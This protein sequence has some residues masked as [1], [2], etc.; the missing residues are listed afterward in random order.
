VAWSCDLLSG[1]HGL[2]EALAWPAAAGGV[3]PPQILAADLPGQPLAE[4]RTHIAHRRAAERAGL[5]G[6]QPAK[7]QALDVPGAPAVH[8][9]QQGRLGADPHL[10]PGLLW[11]GAQ[12]DGQVGQEHQVPWGAVGMAGEQV[13]QHLAVRLRDLAVEQGGGG[14][15]QHPAGLRRQ[16]GQGLVQQDAQVTVI[17]PAGV[18]LLA[19]G[20]GAKPTHQRSLIRASPSPNRLPGRSPRVCSRRQQLAPNQRPL[21]R[22]AVASQPRRPPARVRHAA[23]GAVALRFDL[24]PPGRH[25][26]ATSQGGAMANGHQQ[27]AAHAAHDAAAQHPPAGRPRRPGRVRVG[28]LPA[29]TAPWQARRALER[30]DLPPAIA[31]TGALLVSELVTNS[32]RHAGLGP[33]ELIGLTADWSGTR[34]RVHVHDGGRGRGVQPQAP[35]GSIRPNPGKESGWGLYLAD[36]PASRWGLDAGGY[37][38]E[39]HHSPPS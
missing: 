12:L 20:V 11:P 18:E 6:A 14:D 10:S 25:P 32:V 27:D 3:Q 9:R 28:L 8:H 5:L 21:D 31:T 24:G 29:Q 35:F 16:L 38:F 22:S 17:N 4:L 26:T 39:L 36:R 1:D 15:Y 2:Q 30:L 7:L 19:V 34:L 33:G 23:G 37:W 13:V